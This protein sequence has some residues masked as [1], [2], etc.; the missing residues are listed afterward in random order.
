MLCC[1]CSCASEGEE[2]AALYNL[3]C[4]YC[5]L[6]QRDAALASLEGAIETGFKDFDALR[7]DPDL[8]PLRGPGLEILLAKAKGQGF[9]SS[10]NPFQKKK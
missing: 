3:A 8:A 2:I 5:A 7:S 9:L 6:G 1:Y 4:A 10:L